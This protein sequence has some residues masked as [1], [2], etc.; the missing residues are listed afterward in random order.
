M[1]E[2]LTAKNRDMFEGLH[3]GEL[4]VKQLEDGS[5]YLTRNSLDT[6][7]V[8]SD[9]N[10]IKSDNTLAP[11]LYEMSA[12]RKLLEAREVNI[13][14]NFDAEGFGQSVSSSLG[15]AQLTFNRR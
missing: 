14:N 9:H 1:N 11:L 8:V 12:M 6:D 5:Y 2:E 4:M 7:A 15:R 10:K 13:S 3:R